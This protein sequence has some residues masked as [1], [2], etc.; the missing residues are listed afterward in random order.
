MYNV[1]L[2]INLRIVP[3]YVYQIFVN[4]ILWVF[5]ITEILL[6]LY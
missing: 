5:K 4:F 2:K 3:I 1:A 6:L